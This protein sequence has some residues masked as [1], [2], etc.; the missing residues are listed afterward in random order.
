MKVTITI[1][2]RRNQGVDS[3]ADEIHA[4]LPDRKALGKFLKDIIPAVLPV[5][6]RLVQNQTQSSFIEFGE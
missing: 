3:L 5:K 1:E 2:A 6:F 4:L